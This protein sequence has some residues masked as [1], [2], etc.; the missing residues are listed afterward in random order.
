MGAR[1]LPRKKRLATIPTENQEQTKLVVWMTKANITHFAIPNGGFRNANE[2]FNLKRT[3]VKSGIPDL[4]IPVPT[5]SYHGLYLELKR[6]SGG[7]VSDNQIFWID[8]FNKVGYL[9]VVA[10]GF[11]EAKK[12]ITE[13]LNNEE[14]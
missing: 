2:A 8:Y 11:D 14:H 5:S 12:I 10:R 13:Y 7:R 9:A 6:M 1:M 4:C 3:G